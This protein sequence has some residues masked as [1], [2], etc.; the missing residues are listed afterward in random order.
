MDRTY[1][2]ADLRNRRRAEYLPQ[3]VYEPPFTLQESKELD[4]SIR[5][6]FAG[7]G[8]GTAFLTSVRTE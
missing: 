4:R 7:A 3:E 2:C 5:M 1:G 6:A 8:G